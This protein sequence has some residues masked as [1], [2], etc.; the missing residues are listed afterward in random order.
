MTFMGRDQE[1]KWLAFSLYPLSFFLYCPFKS[2]STLCIFKWTM[3]WL[4]RLEFV[5]PAS[6]LPDT[7][8]LI[9]RQLWT[10]SFCLHFKTK[11]KKI[12]RIFKKEFADFQ[13]FK[14]L[15][16]LKTFKTHF[17][18]FVSFINL[19]CGHVM[20][21]KNLGPIGSPILSFIGYKQTDKPNLYIDFSCRI[22]PVFK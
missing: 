15:T 2:L 1:L 3:Y 5:N 6:S 19:P 4:R 9:T 21:Q 18:T 8:V 14:F 11:K 13:E 12:L 16:K 20:S 10:W 7:V 17:F 22:I